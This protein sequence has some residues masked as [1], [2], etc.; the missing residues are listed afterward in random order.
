MA[1][2]YA[3]LTG[4]P[5][6]CLVSR[7]PGAANASVGI[8]TAHQDSTPVVLLVGQVAREMAAR[9]ALQEVDFRHMYGPLTKW[10]GQIEDPARVPEMVSR[11]FHTA[12]SGRPGPVLLALP[13][14]MQTEPAE[15]VDATPYRAAQASPAAADLETLRAMLGASKR[16]MM[17]IGGSGWTAE[18]CARITAFATA[19]DLPVAN[20]FRRQDL[21]DNRLA[22]Y[23]GDA[24][25]GMNP[26]LARRLTE[27]D[28]LLVVGAQLG[29]VLT[30]GYSLLQVPR[31]RQTVV[32]VL[33]GPEELGKVYEADLPINSG[34]PQFAAAVV[35]LEPVKAA[36]W[37]QWTRD[38]RADYEA[39]ITVDGTRGM[40]DFAHVMVWLRENL[41]DD[42]IVANGAGNFAAWVHRYY[43][44]RRFGTQLAPQSGSMGY[45]V[46][47]AI[48]AKLVHPERTVVSINGDGDFLMNG[49][50]LAT[51]VRYGCDVIFLVVNNGTYGTIRMHQ[52]R[53]Y[54]GRVSGT[55][56][57][58]PDFSAL[59]RAYGAFGEVVETTAGFAPAFR[60]A[61]AAGGPALLELR[62]DQE[63]I[64]PRAT[65]S[66][67]REAAKANKN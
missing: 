45:G 23:A 36:A 17:V 53:S 37:T 16:P 22:N 35:E 27:C 5:G 30:E 2:A 11:A 1:D 40:L 28:L 9:E 43:V 41:P 65:I 52:E 24:G 64:S 48:A 8:H 61:Q 12:A 4:K 3:K 50:E 56:L 62:V 47:A 21:M 34:M 20:S 66:S 19:N 33:A 29:D 67:L 55:D 15:A 6:V 58:N 49:Q 44:Y 14:D 10:V 59:A 7:G 54:P 31:P 25:V 57:V 39:N 38:A 13:E 51:A 26:A 42:A 46:P 60:R 32:H 18:A 63:V